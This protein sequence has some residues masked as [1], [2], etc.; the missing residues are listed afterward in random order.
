[1]HVAGI[2]ASFFIGLATVLY[3]YIIIACLPMSCIDSEEVWVP[4]GFKWYY[5]M[6]QRLL[7]LLSGCSLL[8]LL[9]Y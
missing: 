9:F 7:H 8:S 5:C 1:M 6:S 3:E 2:L 4:L